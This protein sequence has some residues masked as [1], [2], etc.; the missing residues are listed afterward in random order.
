MAADVRGGPKGRLF[1]SHA[2][3]VAG[4]SPEQCPAAFA[5]LGAPFHRQGAALTAAFEKRI[6]G[7]GI[8]RLERAR[9]NRLRARKFGQNGKRRTQGG[10]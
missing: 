1:L 3:S 5:A 4:R 6:D 7:F 9:Q 10:A 8:E 2:I